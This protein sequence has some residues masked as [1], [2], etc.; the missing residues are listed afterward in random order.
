MKAV[1]FTQK[2]QKHAEKVVL[3]CVF[4]RLLREKIGNNSKRYNQDKLL[5]KLFDNVFRKHLSTI[6][7]IHSYTTSG[8]RLP[9]KIRIMKIAL[10]GYGKMGKTIEKMALAQ[11]HEIVLKID[12]SNYDELTSENLRKADVAIE[13]TR[14]ESAMNN[15]LSCFKAGIPIVSGTTGWVEKKEEVDILCKSH[16]GGFF[17]ASNYSVGVNIFFA[18]NRYLAKLMDTQPQ[19]GIEM[20][21]IH[22]TEK[23]DAPSG[24]AITLAEGIMEQ[25]TR[26]KEWINE[27]SKQS[28][29][30]PIISKRIPKVKGTHQVN[31]LSA[32]DDLEIKHVAHSREGFANGAIQ[33]AEWIIG[34]E[35]S[36]GMQDMLGF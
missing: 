29:I 27:P 1:Y 10:I 13:F 21:E 23:L 25:V 30:L 24:T 19:Y 15:I 28:T 9:Y 22:H 14:P 36:F 2:A 7:R 34:K 4:Q 16:K 18:L 6:S 33:A 26:K 3:F 12:I 11:G 20:E 31:Y 5:E 35:G 8:N 32:I 17:Y